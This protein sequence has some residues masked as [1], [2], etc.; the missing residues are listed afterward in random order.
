MRADRQTN[1]HADRITLHPIV[2]EVTIKL[3][4]LP[5]WELQNYYYRYKQKSIWSCAWASGVAME[6]QAIQ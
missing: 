2:D 1:R 5:E 3:E 6:V 4:N